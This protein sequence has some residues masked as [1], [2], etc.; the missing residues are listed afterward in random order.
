MKLT[1]LVLLFS[2]LTVALKRVTPLNGPAPLLMFLLDVVCLAVLLIHLVI[3]L[4]AKALSKMRPVVVLR[5]GPSLVSNV[6]LS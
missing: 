6:R 5:Y 4:M 2:G 3:P 1:T